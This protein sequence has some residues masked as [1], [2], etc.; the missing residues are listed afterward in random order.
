MIVAA[1]ALLMGMNAATIDRRL[2]PQRAKMAFA[3][4]ATPS[5][6]VADLP[7]PDPHLADW[8]DAR[9]EFVEIDLVGHDGDTAAGEF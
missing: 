9:P 5:L 3:G 4:D 1:S 7:D 6:G 2:A 8:D